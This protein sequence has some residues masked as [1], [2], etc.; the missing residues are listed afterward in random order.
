MPRLVS[1]EQGLEPQLSDSRGGTQ[2]MDIS[3][4]N[5]LS[6]TLLQGRLIRNNRQSRNY[7]S[8]SW[9][10]MLCFLRQYF[11]V[12]LCSFVGWLEDKVRCCSLWSGQSSRTI[13]LIGIIQQQTTQKRL[14]YQMRVLE[15]SSWRGTH[16]NLVQST[17]RA[18]WSQ[19]WL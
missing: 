1:A 3:K 16:E 5:T 7:L 6:L 11:H 10:C 8:L 13:G 4:S 19:R 14:F 15:R 2:W 17:S 12:I 18:P 9:E